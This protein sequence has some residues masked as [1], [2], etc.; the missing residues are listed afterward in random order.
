MLDHF[1]DFSPATCSHFT[2]D[3]LKQIQPTTYKFPPPAFVAD[4]MLP[5]LISRKRRER[6]RCVSHETP[7]SVCV[8]CKQKY[9]EKMVSIPE[10]LVRLLTN[11]LMGS[12]VHHEHAK[13]HDMAGDAAR[14]SIVY[15]N[16]GF[17]PDLVSFDVEKAMLVIPLDPD[18]SNGSTYFT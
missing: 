10:G 4:T 8:H 17:G 1:D 15:L 7:R 3:P 16:G 9:Y 11:L 6:L 18:I 14:L 13:Q 2:V 5:E 12:R